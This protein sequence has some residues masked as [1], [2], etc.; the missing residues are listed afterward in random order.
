M[1]SKIILENASF[2]VISKNN[3]IRIL[4]TNITQDEILVGVNGVRLS[5]VSELSTEASN[6]DSDSIYFSE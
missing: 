4:S 5:I 3:V 2:I 1:G 6:S